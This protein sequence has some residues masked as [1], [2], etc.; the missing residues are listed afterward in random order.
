M[1]LRMAVRRSATAFASRPAESSAIGD[2]P[3]GCLNFAA[4]DDDF[5]HQA[6]FLAFLGVQPE[7]AVGIGLHLI[8]VGTDLLR[9]NFRVALA[10][11]QDLL[12]RYFH[13]AGLPE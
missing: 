12:R 6:V 5:I 11:A 8:G 10:R 1:S 3:T 2:A 13:V 7:I 4:R 9:H